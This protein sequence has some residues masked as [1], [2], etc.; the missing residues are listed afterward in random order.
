MEVTRPDKALYYG[1]D[2]FDSDNKIPFMLVC[3]DPLASPWRLPSP[4]ELTQIYTVLQKAGKADYG[5]Y[6]YASNK[7]SIIHWAMAPDQGES[8]PGF[9]AYRIILANGGQVLF[10]RVQ[11]TFVRLKDGAAKEAYDGEIEGYGYIASTEGAAL[12]RVIYVRSFDPSKP[13][14]KVPAGK[15]TA[16][17]MPVQLTFKPCPY[18]VGGTGPKGGVVWSVEEWKGVTE[19]IYT[20]YEALVGAPG[21]DAVPPAGW[22]FITDKGQLKRAQTGGLKL[23][24]PWYIMYAGKEEIEWRENGKFVKKVPADTARL[25]NPATGEETMAYRIE[26]E[27][28]YNYKKV[29]Y[30]YVPDPAL[31]ALVVSAPRVVYASSEIKAEVAR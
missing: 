2:R 14:A 13:P 27:T 12:G 15:P 3:P 30:D 20:V 9:P 21:P 22:Y 1:E 25:Y 8:V 10:N 28:G 24:H 31:N 19:C 18:T 6:W 16:P 11:R 4:A 29:G 26:G 5:D 23:E 7:A 17:P